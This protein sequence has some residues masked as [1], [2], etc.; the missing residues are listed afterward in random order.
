[1]WRTRR[2]PRLIGLSHRLFE[3]R[4]D[5][6]MALLGCQSHHGVSMLVFGVDVCSMFEQKFHNGNVLGAT[7]GRCQKEWRV[8]FVVPGF[9]ICPSG[10]E[11]FCGFSRSEGA[12]RS[13]NKERGVTA[14]VP[15]VDMGAVIQKH[16]NDFG[17]PPACG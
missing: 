10:K 5:F 9:D 17:S 16:L 8:A 11:Q 4:D 6:G 1:M 12:S 2:M 13:G 15:G 14:V 3:Q 7:F